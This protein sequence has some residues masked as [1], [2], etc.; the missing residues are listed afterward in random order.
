MKSYRAFAVLLRYPHRHWLAALDEVEAVLHAERWRNR[1][2]LPQIKPLL[3]YLRTTP[4]L[5]LEEHY[6]EVFDRQPRH[7][8]YLYEHLH[9]ESRARGNA[10]VELLKKYRETGLELD[11]DELP[12]HLPVFLEFLSELPARAAR[13]ELGPVAGVFGLLARRLAEA[14]TPYAGVLTAVERLAHRG[15][16]RNEPKSPHP[17]EALMQDTGHAETGQEPL[18][19]PDAVMRHPQSRREE[20]S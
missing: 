9:G 2:A 3:V 17:M 10:M 12:D 18:L 1:L 8:L 15:A 6:V 14:K 13:R 4:L 20:S 5:V 7:A 19:T 16:T 11:C